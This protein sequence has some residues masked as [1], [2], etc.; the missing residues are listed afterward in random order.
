[1]LDLKNHPYFTEYVD[2]VSGAVSYFLTEK[3]AGLQQ[4][5]YFSECS[6]TEDGKYL[7]ICCLN[8]PAQFRY[9]AV[10]SMDPENPFIRPFLGAGVQGGNPNI[11]PG[12]HDVLF[13]QGSTMWRINV[14]GEMT[15]V[16]TL[17]EDFLHNRVPG[18][19]TTHSS[20][21]CDG[22]YVVLDIRLTGF[23]YVGIGDMETGEFKL[24]N[25][26]GRLYDHA[27]FSP[28]NPEL[29]LIDQDWWRDWHTGEYF[30]LDNRMW[31]MDI[32]GTRFEPVIPNAWYGRDGSEICHDFWAKDGT[33]CWIDYNKGAFECDIETREI[34]HVWKRPT[35][36]AHTTKDRMFWCA[37]QTPYA[38]KERPCQTLFYDRATNKEIEIISANPNPKVERGGVYH[39]D[40]HPSFTTDDEYIISTTTLVGGSADVAITPVK[41]L[42][43][44]CREKGTVVGE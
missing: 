19:L 8:A 4:Q 34:T 42:V 35:C 16:L 2:P 14:E 7:W 24:L 11:I 38:W 36:H 21:S 44:L 13:P 43:E 30:C 1:M 26:F 17:P 27:Q 10:V 20:I 18:S 40:P 29:F 5:F 9:L 12:T 25:N 15:K 28:T 31:L 39:L 32:H 41:P 6:L 37:D 33:L 23:T 22:K 3:V